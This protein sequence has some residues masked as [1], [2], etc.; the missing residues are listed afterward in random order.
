MNSRKEGAQATIQPGY[1]IR[2]VPDHVGIT[3]ALSAHRLPTW[4]AVNLLKMEVPPWASAT[5]FLQ[6][7]VEVGPD[8]VSVTFTPPQAGSSTGGRSTWVRIH[9]PEGDSVV[10]FGGD[11]EMV[12]CEGETLGLEV[13]RQASS[14]IA[15]ADPG[16]LSTPW[17]D[18]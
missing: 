9:S 15:W 10:P 5:G 2:H 3:G 12:G 17:A 11:A 4:G 13:G 14:Q 8:S 6:F 1:V 18:A 16:P 7:P